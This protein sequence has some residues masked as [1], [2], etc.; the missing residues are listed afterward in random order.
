MKNKPFASTKINHETQEVTHEAMQMHRC[1]NCEWAGEEDELKNAGNI[2]DFNERVAPG[3]PCPSGECPECGAVCHPVTPT[4]DG[5]TWPGLSDPSRIAR[6]A[7]RYVKAQIE[8]SEANEALKEDWRQ[9]VANDNTVLGFAEWVDHKLEAEAYD[10]GNAV[11]SLISAT[12][13]LIDCMLESHESELTS[14]HGGDADHDGE[15]P[16]ACSYCEGVDQAR[17]AIAA[18]KG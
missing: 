7:T 9:E 15:A 17:M 10:R 12:Q 3:E 14:Q 4:N 6:L 8:I 18:V 1:Q 11:T 13:E 2:P 16:E 5:R